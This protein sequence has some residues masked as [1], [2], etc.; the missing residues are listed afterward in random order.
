MPLET[1]RVNASGL[2]CIFIV[3][4]NICCCFVIDGNHDIMF[5]SEVQ[6][7]DMMIFNLNQTQSKQ[8][9]YNLKTASTSTASFVSILQ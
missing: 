6:T 9:T 7:V 5:V 3:A 1:M 4:C 2:S 8:S